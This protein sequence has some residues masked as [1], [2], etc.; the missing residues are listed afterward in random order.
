MI[1]GVFQ[2]KFGL[3]LVIFLDDE[4]LKKVVFLGFVASEEEVIYEV[5]LI[6]KK[7]AVEDWGR[8]DD[9]VKSVG[10]DV[11]NGLYEVLLKGS[12]FQMMVW[13]ELMKTMPGERISYGELALRCG[14][15]KAVRAVA[16]AVGRNEISVLVPCHRIVRADGSV[17][18]YRWGSEVKSKLLESERFG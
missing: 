7:F 4:A 15:P 10:E 3:C 14:C 6:V 13:K 8:D 1:Y 9:F 18:K 11:L 5:E 16:T 12:D 17:G 2:S